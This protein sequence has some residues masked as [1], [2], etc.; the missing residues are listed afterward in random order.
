MFWNHQQEWLNFEG[1]QIHVAV[2]S[3]KEMIIELPHLALNEAFWDFWTN[4]N[5]TFG[6]MGVSKNRGVSHKMDDLYM[7]NH[8]KMDDLGGK[9]TIFGNWKNRAKQHRNRKEQSENM[10]SAKWKGNKWTKF[11]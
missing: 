1:E 5:I 7:E 2:V 4:S 6:Y 3:L 8:I 9:P 10:K 11:Y